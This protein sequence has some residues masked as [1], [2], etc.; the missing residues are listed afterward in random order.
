MIR[1][2]GLLRLLLLLLLLQG[3]MNCL[4][5]A[6]KESAPYHQRLLNDIELDSAKLF[7]GQFMAK[8]LAHQP[9][10]L[11]KELEE[12]IAKLEA[13]GEALKAALVRLHL[14]IVLLHYTKKEQARSYNLFIR[15][16]NT[17]DSLNYTPGLAACYY[18]WGILHLWHFQ[19]ENYTKEKRYLKQAIDLAEQCNDSLVLI[20]GYTGL[21]LLAQHAKNADEMFTHYQKALGLIE[22][23]HALF[24][25]KAR[26]CLNISDHYLSTRQLDSAFFYCHKVLSNVDKLHH[27]S[28]AATCYT[29]LG[30]AL[31]KQGQLE[32]SKTALMQAYRIQKL[33]PNYRID[34]YTAK[35][36]G[37]VA[38]KM[39]DTKGSLQ[40]ARVAW[41]LKNQNSFM[42]MS[43]PMAILEH[44][45]SQTLRIL[46]LENEKK[47]L[48]LERANLLIA[49]AGSGVAMLLLSIG[50][51]YWK[52]QSQKR[53][54]Q[55]LKKQKGEI[56]WL[57][58][59]IHHRVKNNLQM[60]SSLLEL[61]YSSIKDKSLAHTLNDARSRVRSIS[62]V[63][64]HLFQQADATS[65]LA[66]GQYLQ[67]LCD[68]LFQ[69]YGIDRSDFDLQLHVENI[70]LKFDPAILIGLII[71]ELIT[72]SLK[73]GFPDKS[74]HKKLEVSLKFH[75]NEEL[76]LK[77]SDNGQ[78][79]PHLFG[80]GNAPS[81][82]FDLI[83][84]LADRL[85]GNVRMYNQ[86]GAVFE[87]DIPNGINLL[88]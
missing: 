79:Y 30:I 50:L 6:P 23:S 87:L 9:Q 17:F 70:S 41:E 69:A 54:S 59:E 72:N 5:Q 16:F 58:K 39:N 47:G 71:N 75:D 37:R 61:Q 32:L 67:Q 14:H 88:Q 15:A 22:S 36:L 74:V 24:D 48:R 4:G 49:L 52:Y 56:Q 38:D 46:Q 11:K 31:I 66:F 10:T 78:G 28:W 64:K 57:L 34:F 40:W 83:H 43:I 12:R 53:F 19:S 51:L 84:S 27:P 35:T 21:G 7:S 13:T 55:T 76:C 63:H 65:G 82:G 60:I 25:K 26:I 73:H 18:R 2:F 62:L 29:N 77:V 42:K 81:F 20:D 80:V 45:S 3:F 86:D 1:Q 8:V 85:E 44:E 33:V 68:H